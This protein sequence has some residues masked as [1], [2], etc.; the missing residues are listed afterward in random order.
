MPKHVE[1]IVVDFLVEVRL[2]YEC[3]AILRMRSKV[4][5]V[6]KKIADRGLILELERIYFEGVL[7]LEGRLLI[8][9]D[10]CY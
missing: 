3:L 2:A 4:H 8:F 1:E 9:G 10:A 7:V 5:S 6:P